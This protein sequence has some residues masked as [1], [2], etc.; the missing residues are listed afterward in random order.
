MVVISRCGLSWVWDEWNGCVFFLEGGRGVLR[1]LCR[2]CCDLKG[3][4]QNLALMMS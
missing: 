1:G 4:E 3:A 2:Y